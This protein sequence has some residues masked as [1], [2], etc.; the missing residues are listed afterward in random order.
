MSDRNFKSKVIEEDEFEDVESPAPL[1]I[2]MGS[3]SVA[4]EQVATGREA[5][6]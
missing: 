1:S 2:N 3:R 4:L 6:R 5:M